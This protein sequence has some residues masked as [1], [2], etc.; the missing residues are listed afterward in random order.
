MEKAIQQEYSMLGFQG[1]PKE[2]VD[3]KDL[4]PL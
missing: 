4:E 2:D 3:L 1:L